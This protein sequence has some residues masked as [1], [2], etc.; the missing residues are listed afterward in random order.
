[1]LKRDRDRQ[2]FDPHRPAG[3]DGIGSAELMVDWT[4]GEVLSTGVFRTSVSRLS[5]LSDETPVQAGANA[6]T[7]QFDDDDDS[8]DVSAA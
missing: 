5:I 8:T 4:G 2:R 3:A 7:L 6:P 1:M